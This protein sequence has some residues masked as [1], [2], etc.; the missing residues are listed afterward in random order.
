MLRCLYSSIRGNWSKM[1]LLRV[2]KSGAGDG[3]RSSTL[4]QILSATDGS[5]K[6]TKLEWRVIPSRIKY[7]GFLS[8][9]RC[10]GKLNERYT[11]VFSEALLTTGGPLFLQE[12]SSLYTF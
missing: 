6:L 12:Q 11:T 1:A 9:V 4:C 10:S 3:R 5:S 7:S 2:S 8:D